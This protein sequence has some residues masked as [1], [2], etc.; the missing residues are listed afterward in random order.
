MQDEQSLLD[1][2]SPREI[3]CEMQIG[4]NSYLEMGFTVEARMSTS[5]SNKVYCTLKTCTPRLHVSLL[6]VCL[7]SKA[8]ERSVMETRVVWTKTQGWAPWSR[9]ILHPTSRPPARVDGC[10]RCPVNMLTSMPRSLSLQGS[11]KA[12]GRVNIF[13]PVIQ[14]CFQIVLSSRAFPDH[15]KA[16][17]HREQVTCMEGEN[18]CL[19]AA[20]RPTVC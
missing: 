12:D 4:L 11:R 7:A 19:Q 3:S 1:K 18:G 8:P 16:I 2:L 5:S 9:P 17:A 6:E 15:V 10:C 14:T 13:S 20:S